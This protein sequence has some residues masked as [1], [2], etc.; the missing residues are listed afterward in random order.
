[1]LHVALRMP[2]ERSLVVDGADVVAEVHEVLDRMAAFCERVRCGEWRG[3][4]GKP[5][6]NVVNIGIGGSDLGPVMA[7][8]ALRHYSRREMTLPLRLQR[9]RHRLRR[10]DPRP[11]PGRDAVRRLLEDVHDAGD[12]DQ[13]PHRPGVAARPASAATSARSPST[14][15]PSRPTPR[16]WPSSGSTPTTCSGSGTGSAAATR[17]TRRSG[18]RPCSRSGRSASREMLAGFHAVDEHFRE[19]PTRRT[20]RR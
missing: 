2:R 16:G 1:M 11:R 12:D 14:S 8:E 19:A 5:I 10:G 17:W 9:R 20:C 18:S 13:R 3:H 7:Y 4:T 15:S 6:R